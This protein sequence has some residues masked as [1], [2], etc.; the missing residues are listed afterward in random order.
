MLFS[1][2]LHTAL[3]G[4]K[5]NRMRSL[6]TT[7][8]IIIGVGSVVL[9]VSIGTSF[10][11]YILDQVETFSG[12]TFEVNAK[13]MEQVG[14]DINTITFGD[15]EAIRNLSTVKNIAPAIFV[16]ERVQYGTKQIAPYIFGTTKELFANWSMKIGEGR[17]LTDA[18]VKGAASVAV[19]GPQAAE[20]LF[21]NQNPLGK[22]ITI[23][24]RKFTVVGILEEIGS[25]LASQLE[26]IV[27]VP[28]T[29]A[30][31]MM[32]RT[33]YVDYISLQSTGDN[34]M[35]ELDI[36]TLLRQRHN[37]E[38]P[39]N[40]PDKDD[41]IARSFAQATEIIGTVTMSITLFLGLIASISLLVGGVGIMNI[42]LVSVTER[43]R[44]IGLRKA[45]G[46]RGRDILLQFL[47]EA[48]CLT[49]LGGIIG[50]MGGVVL[51][52]VLV[53]V[54]AKFLGTIHYT[55]S[56]W[57]VV[58]SLAT[59]IGIGL[60]FGIFPARKAAQLTPIQALGYE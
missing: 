5:R 48:V 29:V 26:S 34:E 14:K 51:G 35:T 4:L 45:V 37:I 42:M 16:T 54:A 50:L 47:F 3:E 55:L 1:D 58:A 19:L 13:G 15:V 43:T 17:L 41:F 39:D 60:A 7:L 33:A 25:P 30:K 9:M 49:L 21:E 28:F 56:L 52:F 2:T 46:A 18:D 38:N 10:Q 53:L 36:T 20:D 31:A 22:R 8:G 57:A 11:R 40:D 23:G 59:S 12:D 32:G 24:S 27:Y 44:E 6:L